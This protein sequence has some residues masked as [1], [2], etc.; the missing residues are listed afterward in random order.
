MPINGTLMC[1]KPQLHPLTNRRRVTRKSF[2]W[3]DNRID[4]VHMRAPHQDELHTV[5]CNVSNLIIDEIGHE[6]Q[7]YPRCADEVRSC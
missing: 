3:N 2:G 5:L 4:T 1:Y 7:Y 6:A